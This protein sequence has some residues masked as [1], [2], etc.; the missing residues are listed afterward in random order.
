MSG[1]SAGANCWFKYANSDAPILEGE[2]GVKTT[3][4]EGLSLVDVALCPHMKR[5][6][7]R[8]E[9]F[10]TMMHTTPGVG[11]GL[12]DNCAIQVRGQEYRFLA[13]E[14]G[15][16]AHKLFWEGEKLHHEYLYPTEDFHALSTLI[17]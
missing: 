15:A 13:A 12:D 6:P 17:G 8:L 16:K 9:E 10:A 11:I 7:F 4:V 14:D 3:R 1:L 2:E 5:E